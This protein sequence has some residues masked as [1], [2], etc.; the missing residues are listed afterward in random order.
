M[1]PYE[2]EVNMT[3]QMNE[4]GFGCASRVLSPVYSSPKFQE[5]IYLCEVLT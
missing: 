1:G 3:E 4:P 2:V 5:N